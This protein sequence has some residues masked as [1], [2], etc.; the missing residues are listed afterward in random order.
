MRL[1]WY[2]TVCS[3]LLPLLQHPCL[4][5]FVIVCSWALQAWAVGN[6]ALLDGCKQTFDAHFLD[7]EGED[8]GLRKFLGEECQL[9]RENNTAQCWWDWRTQGFEGPGCVFTS[10]LECMC[11][12]LTD[13]QAVM[14]MEVGQVQVPKVR[15]KNNRT[16]DARTQCAMREFVSTFACVRLRVW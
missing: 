3:N 12:H 2:C 15:P 5:A 8:A 1:C 7:Y 9:S 10:S 6:L 13:F 4:I 11:T 14:Q 16:F